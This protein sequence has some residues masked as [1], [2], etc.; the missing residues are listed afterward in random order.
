MTNPYHMLDVKSQGENAT[1]PAPAIC[2]LLLTYLR[3]EMAVATV[4]SF[5]EKIDYPKEL[6]SFYI[7]DDGSPFEH[8]QTLINEIQKGGVSVAGYHN[9]KM[10][11]GTC[12]VGRGW[13][14]GLQ[15]AHKVSDIVLLLEDDWEL[16]YE[17]D[18]RPYIRLLLELPEVGIVRLSGLPVGGEVRVRGWNGVH[19]LEYLRTTA[20]GYSGNPHLR[21]VRYTEFYG[22]FAIDR[23][24]GDVEVNYDERFQEF[25]DGPN[26]WRPADLP[27]YGIFG[28]LGRERTW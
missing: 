9:E 10:M 21:H 20:M 7:A 3:T 18:I 24:P 12:F 11:P 22:L 16:R 23:S 2:V 13:N 15:Q 17:L 5:C 1:I 28:H 14:Y 27:A 8:V 25:K 19:Y 4:K 6:L 26:I